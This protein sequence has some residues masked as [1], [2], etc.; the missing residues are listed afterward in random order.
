MCLQTGNLTSA[1]ACSCA[2]GGLCGRCA[3][4]LM[5]NPMP[6]GHAET[7]AA[8]NDCRHPPHT[9]LGS[10]LKPSAH[11]VQLLALEQV[12]QMSGQLITVFSGVV[13]AV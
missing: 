2:A 13:M 3:W 8:L 6:M 1:T 4:S 11:W 7:T 5:Y 12:L 10:T 9:P